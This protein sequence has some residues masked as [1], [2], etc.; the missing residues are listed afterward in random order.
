MANGNSKREKLESMLRRE[1][2]TAIA[3][4]YFNNPDGWAISKEEID[5]IINRSTYRVCYDPYHMR[6]LQDIM[7]WKKPKEV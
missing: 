4:V 5:K 7:D 2:R 1:I 3:E 6:E